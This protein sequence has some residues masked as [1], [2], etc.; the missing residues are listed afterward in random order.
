[1]S[2]RIM[3]PLGMMPNKVVV[4]EFSWW[5]VGFAKIRFQSDVKLIGDGTQKAN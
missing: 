2:E 5:H 4:E 3:A 1:M